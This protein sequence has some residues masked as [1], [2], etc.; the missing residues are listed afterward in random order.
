MQRFCDT[1]D[2]G[3]FNGQSYTGLDIEWKGNGWYRFTGGST[4]AGFRMPDE[5]EV[6]ALVRCGTGFTGY[7][8]NTHPTN[9]LETKDVTYC[10]RGAGMTPNLCLYDTT[11]KVTNCGF[12]YV[13]YLVNVP[14]ECNLGY[15]GTNDP[16]P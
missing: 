8:D 15:C 1:T 12:F 16:L 13:Y 7:M 11:G 9:F 6:P 4:G 14:N 3:E 10:F 5:S 2:T